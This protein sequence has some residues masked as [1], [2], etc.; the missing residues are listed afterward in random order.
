M[1]NWRFI[2]TYLKNFFIIGGIFISMVLFG[3]CKGYNFKEVESPNKKYNIILFL[4]DDLGWQDT[5]LSLGLSEDLLPVK[6]ISTPNLTKLAE[7][8]VMFSNAYSTP[9]CSPSRISLLTGMNAARHKVTNWTLYPNQMQPMEQNHPILE[10]PFW[11]VNGLATSD[12]IPNA[13]NATPLPEVLSKN[14]YRTMHFGK[15]HFGALGYP[16]SDPINLGFEINVGGHAAGAPGSYLG[17][18]SFRSL[19][20]ENEDVFAVPD[21]EDYFGQD[22]FLTTALT[23][24]ALKKLEEG[25]RDRPFFLYMSY[26]G[27]HIPITPDNRF[28][29]KYLDKGMDSIEAN[30]ASMVESVDSSIG[31]IL[32]Y[33]ESTNQME[34]T[35]VLFMSDNGGLSALS[36][37][38][39]SHTHN[40]PLNSG[41]G[42]IYEGGIRVPMVVYHPDYKVEK[43]TI[44][45]PIIIEDFFPSILDFAGIKKTDLKQK[46][47]GISFKPLMDDFASPELDSRSLFWHY[48]N[49]WGPEG[50]GIGAFSAV[51]NGNWKLIYYHDSMDFEL[52][53][54]SEDIGEI[55]NLF[56]LYPSIAIRLSQLMSDHLRDSD[57][58]MPVFKSNRETVPFPDE[59]VK[60]KLFE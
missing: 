40:L 31:S 15:A 58:Q 50:P 13:I 2:N 45:T 32:S 3:S 6:Y 35:I 39:D 55:E 5:S 8:G 53:N 16:S 11:N 10:F 22:I 54:L 9:V 24:E 21:L 49:D 37:G 29:E 20:H 60:S 44:H 59:M 41:K 18:D 47:D 38:G 19:P 17:I 33:L 30:Y 23:N 51:R 12:S 26:Y 46:V 7:R 48:P 56:K 34:E 1:V 27:V 36:R 57:A 43:R 4:V 25:N 52:F 28:V 14:G 42:S